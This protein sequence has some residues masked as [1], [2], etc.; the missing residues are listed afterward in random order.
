M[1]AIVWLALTILNIM[2][3]MVIVQFILSWLIAFN[4]INTSQP[5][6]YSVVDFLNKVT[7]PL[8]RPIRRHI[9][10]VG[11]FDLS[12]LV[13]ILAIGFTQRIIISLYYSSH[14]LFY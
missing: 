3:W 6:I 2:W 1:N 13:L 11:G 12:P 5:L 10:L 8:Y 4:I 14:G 9:P 7:E